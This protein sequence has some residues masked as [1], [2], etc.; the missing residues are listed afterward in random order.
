L[1]DD[2]ETT[3]QG[4]WIGFDVEGKEEPVFVLQYGFDFTP[5]YMQMHHLSLPLPVQCFMVG[6]HFR[7]LRKWKKLEGEMSGF[8]HK[9]KIIHTNRGTKKNKEKGTYHFF[10]WETCHS[11]LGPGLVEMD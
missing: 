3:Y 11:R 7:C 6:T 10:L 9:V 1:E 2:S 8:F 4:D 5:T